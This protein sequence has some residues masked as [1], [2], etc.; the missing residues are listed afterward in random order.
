MSKALDLNSETLIDYFYKNLEGLSNIKEGYKLYINS[1]NVI[2]PDEPY[3]FQGLWRYYNNIKRQDAINVITNLFDN[4]ERY[5]NSL[6]IKSCISK[7]KTKNINLP[8]TVINEFKTIIDK[9]QLSL[10]GIKHLLT[11]YEKDP[12][13][14]DLLNKIIINVNTMI[15]NFTKLSSTNFI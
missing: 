11:T 5:Y 7:N 14:V 9:M 6:Y 10:L 1:D 13:T 4:I 15:F 3:M 12:I 8:E 2:I